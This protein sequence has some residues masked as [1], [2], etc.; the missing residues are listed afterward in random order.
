[1]KNVQTSVKD[2]ILTL[3]VNLKQTYGASKSGKSTV[4]ASTKGNLLVEGTKDT[5]VGL[6]VYKVEKVLSKDLKVFRLVMLDDG[7][8]VSPYR[9]HPVD[10]GRNEVVE[11]AYIQDGDEGFHCYAAGFHCYAERKYAKSEAIKSTTAFCQYGVL[12]G[13]IPAGTSVILGEEDIFITRGNG[14]YKTCAVSVIVT[15]V[16]FHKKEDCTKLRNKLIKGAYDAAIRP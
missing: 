2:G 15:P 6:N 7:D 11:R 12:P 16:I 3:T 10:A 5:Y 1:M 8:L 9:A 4:I 13:I 14:I